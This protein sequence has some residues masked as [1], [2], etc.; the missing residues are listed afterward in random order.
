MFRV[1]PKQPP[2]E[3]FDRGLFTFSI[4]ITLKFLLIKIIAGQITCAALSFFYICDAQYIYSLQ[5]LLQ[6]N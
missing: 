3:N 6:P 5:L 1:L 2:A 4:I